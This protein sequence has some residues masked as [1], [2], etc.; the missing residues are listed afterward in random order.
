MPRPLRALLVSLL[1]ASCEAPIELSSPVACDAGTACGAGGARRCVD[2]QRDPA[3]CGACGRACASGVVCASG[4]CCEGQSCGE[5]CHG[6]SFGPPQTAQTGRETNRVYLHDLDRDGYDDV[7]AVNQLDEDLSV[8]WGNAEGR[9]GAPTRWNI[10]RCNAWLAFGD[11]DRDGSQDFVAAIQVDGRVDLSVYRT[12][13]GRTLAV[14]RGTRFPEEGYLNEV[15]LIDTDRDGLLDLV[16][17]RQESGCLLV[18]R[19]DGRGAFAP[20][21]CVAMIPPSPEQPSR[22]A[23][24]DVDGDGSRELFI[25]QPAGTRLVRFAADGSVSVQPDPVGREALALFRDL[26]ATDVDRDGQSEL[27]MLQRGPAIDGFSLRWYPA[28]RS[29]ATPPCTLEGTSQVAMEGAGD[30]NGDG[31]LDVYGTQSCAGCPYTL[32]MLLRR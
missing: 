15:A 27:I 31:L 26:D 12:V 8:F 21:R 1:L 19:G 16:A 9:L 17:R 7:I 5:R 2:L 18:R 24:V 25:H 23:A 29:L 10:G 4:R 28:G 11:L 6:V 20:G 32:H 30:F 13:R 3:N 14:E 22:F